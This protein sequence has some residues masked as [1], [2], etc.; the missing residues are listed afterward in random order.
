MAAYDFTTLRLYVDAPLASQ[1]E[2]AIT[3]D[4]ANYL[5]N[6]MRLREGA[7]ILVFNGIDGEWV[8]TLA[9]TTKRA[10]DLRVDARVREQTRAP[11]IEYWFAPLKHAR[12]DYVVQKAVEMGVGRL[13]PVRTRRT[14]T[15]RVNIERMRA[16]VVEAAEQCGVLALPEVAA[17]ARLDAL[18]DAREP[19]RVLILCDEDAP[20]GSPVASLQA[21]PPAT[22]HALL[23]GP[24][25]GFDPAERGALLAQ[26]NLVR[27]SLG[28]RI[29][30]ADTAAVAALALVQTIRGDWR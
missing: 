11:D 3:G 28:P 9:N 4:R 30:R 10:T 27:L 16:N 12:L 25:G 18:L 26:P 17:E 22:K 14:Q 15:T 19:D 5:L 20:P 21:A 29:L 8:A 23:I 24:E 1:S 6:V 13:Q 7:K 2:V